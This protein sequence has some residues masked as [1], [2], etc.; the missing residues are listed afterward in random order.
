[1]DLKYTYGGVKWT[2]VEGVL[3]MVE[4]K[5]LFDS[6][7]LCKWGDNLQR[8]N[9]MQMRRTHVQEK[10]VEREREERA[11]ITGKR[12]KFCTKFVSKNRLWVR[13]YIQ[14]STT[15]MWTTRIR[16]KDEGKY[17]SETTSLMVVLSGKENHK[18]KYICTSGRLRVCVWA[19]PCACVRVCALCSCAP[20][21]SMRFKCDCVVQCCNSYIASV[22]AHTYLLCRVLLAFVVVAVAVIPFRF[23]IHCTLWFCIKS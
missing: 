1:M 5:I 17:I 6:I 2:P 4:C 8:V 22:C 11:R 14:Q 12:T 23:A 9:W 10:E 18:K 3:S 13:R 7:E 21:Y 16:K 19:V 20:I 15:Y